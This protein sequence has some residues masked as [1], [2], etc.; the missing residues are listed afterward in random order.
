MQ[1]IE[2]LTNGSDKSYFL[3]WTDIASQSCVRPEPVS[4]GSGKALNTEKCRKT[5]RNSIFE[6]K[7]G[8]SF[9]CHA[10]AGITTGDDHTV[11]R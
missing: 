5:S 4:E 8:E 6:N 2:G 3:V 10:H 9:C 7:K 1:Q 11:I